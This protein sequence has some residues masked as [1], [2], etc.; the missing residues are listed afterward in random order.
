[1]PAELQ[2]RKARPKPT[3][4]H[5]K[6]R[7]KARAD[8]PATS[9]KSIET[10]K[11]RENLTLHDWLTVFTFID[12]HP[13][14]PQERVVEHFKTRRE[15]ALEFTQ[16]TLSRKLKN[17]TELEQRVNSHPNALSGKRPRAVTSPEVEKAL[18]FWV[19]RHW[20]FG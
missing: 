7:E 18:V 2:T 3:P 5:R 20:S 12:S 1:M 4:Y 17:R 16:S 10:K 6:P 15:G 14:T 11:C 19:R 8:A 9:A 13:D